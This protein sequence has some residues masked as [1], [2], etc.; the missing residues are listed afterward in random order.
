M[1]NRYNVQYETLE[2]YNFSCHFM[3]FFHRGTILSQ[4]IIASGPMIAHGEMKEVTIWLQTIKEAD[5]RIEY[6]SES[7]PKSILQK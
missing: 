4:S 1:L 5:C 7:D 6:T 3:F 2:I